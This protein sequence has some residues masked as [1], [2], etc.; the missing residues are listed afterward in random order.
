MAVHALVL[1]L[2]F[3]VGKTAG[4]SFSCLFFSDFLLGKLAE[5]HS[6]VFFCRFSVGTPGGNSFSCFF[7]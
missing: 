6:L 5:I 1:F 2:R 4:N 7:L 3:F